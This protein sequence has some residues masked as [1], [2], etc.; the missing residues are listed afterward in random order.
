VLDT[1]NS[2]FSKYGAT[3]TPTY[4]VLDKSGTI[5]SRFEGVVITDAFYKA[6]DLALST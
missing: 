1:D 4:F 3:A 2:V 6:I 5:L